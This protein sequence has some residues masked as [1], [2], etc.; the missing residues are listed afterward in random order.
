VHTVPAFAVDAIDTTGAGD[1]FHGA[2]TFAIGARATQRDAIRFSSVVA[3][4]KCAHAGGREGA[5]DL[6]A[7]LSALQQFKESSA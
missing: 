2:Y 7:A 5:P 3:A 4:L 1:V 6:A